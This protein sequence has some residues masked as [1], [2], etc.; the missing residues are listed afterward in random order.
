VVRHRDVPRV[1]AGGAPPRGAPRIVHDLTDEPPQRRHLAFGTLLATA[2]TVAPLAASAGVSL[3]IA[4]LL[5]P[6]GTGTLSLVMNLFDVTLI[7]VGLGLSSGVTYLVSR[8]EWP[9]AAAWR[10]LAAA[11]VALGLAGAAGGFAFYALTRH[12]VLKGV[13][14]APAIVALASMP[15]AMWWAFAAAAA[16]GRDRYEAYTSLELTHSAVVMFG[17]VIAAIVFGL[18]GAVAGFAAANAVTAVVGTRWLVRAIRRERGPERPARERPLRRAT[19]FGLQAWSPNL[20]QLVNYRLDIFILAAFA[21]RSAV[22]V[23]AIAVSVTGLGWVLPN[24]FTTVLFPR[25]GA[26]D[27]AAVSGADAARASDAAASRAIRHAVLIVVPTALALAVIL[28]VIPVL[29][30][31]RFTHSLV[32]GFILIPGV[33]GMIVAKVISA[34]LTGRGFPRYALYNTLITAPITVALYVGLISLWH[35]AG[36]AL[37]TTISYALTTALTIFY[38]RRGTPIPLREALVPTAADVRDYLDALRAARG[39]LAQRRSSLRS[40]G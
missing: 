6:T 32:L 21:T 35:A 14:P 34:V 7:I 8:G 30:G 10:P 5:G 16:L 29:Y 11:S 37:A 38:L 9:L 31:S 23:Y 17:G 18:V 33:L 12:S 2:A 19:R 13:A 20:L 4:R 1:R 22:G 15:F 3:A 28:L 36:A 27:A 24:A 39:R 26:L 40:P 25:I